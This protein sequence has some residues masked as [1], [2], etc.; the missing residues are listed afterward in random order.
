MRNESEELVLLHDPIVHPADPLDGFTELE[1]DTLKEVG[2]I[3][4]GSSATILSQLVSQPVRINTPAIRYRTA[5]EIQQSFPNPCVLVAVEY[6]EGLSGKNLLIINTEDASVIGQL[7]MMEEPQ[8]NVELSEIHLS[9]VSEAMNQMMGAAA[10]SM[11]S[12]FDRMINISFPQIMHSQPGMLL[13]DN[14]IFSGYD[15]FVQVAFRLEVPGYI[16][17]ELLQ[18]MPVTFARQAVDYLL[19]GENEGSA[20]EEEDDS[21]CGSAEEILGADAEDSLKEMANIALGS[22]ATALSQLTSRTVSITSPELTYTTLSNLKKSCISNSLLAIVEYVQG[23][24]GH[25][26]MIVSAR[27]AVTIGQLMMMEEPDGRAEMNEIY[28]SALSE[29]MNMMMGAAATAM[30]EIFQRRIDISAPKIQVVAENHFLSDTDPLFVEAN[31]IQISFNLQIGNDVDSELLH[32][33]PLSFA[34]QAVHSLFAYS[35]G[36]SPES[37]ADASEMDEDGGRTNDEAF[38]ERMDHPVSESYDA[39]LALVKHIILEVQGIAGH[40]KL[41]LSR[42]MELGRGSVVELNTEVGADIQVTINGKQIASAEIVA[43][44]N[45]YGLRLTEIFR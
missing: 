29:A 25:N 38:G 11:S 26:L 6:T 36:E 28:A 4:L 15:G 1:K 5:E 27:D 16:D 14:S 31:Y 41:P 40:A 2:N 20:C 17:S 32:L 13:D 7:M 3:S 9:A 23:L 18:L 33:I 10:T 12:M 35:K 34:K 30:S 44:G 21:N 8:P 24:Q 19:Q 42:I 39:D 45:Q 37:D 22:S 43:V